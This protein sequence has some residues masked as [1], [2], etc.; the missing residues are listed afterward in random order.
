MWFWPYCVR[1]GSMKKYRSLG[2]LVL[3]LLLPL[4]S[5]IEAQ[6]SA[7]ESGRMAIDGAGQFMNA[8]VRLEALEPLVRKHYLRQN[9]YHQ[10]KYEPWEYT[11]YAREKYN[12]YTRVELEGE[13]WYD[14][15]GGYIT[16]GFGIYSWSQQQPQA[17]GSDVFKR[18][19]YRNWFNNVVIASDKKGQFYTALTVAD[20]IRTTLTPLTFSK[21]AFGGLQWDFLSDKYELTFLASRVSS[22]GFTAQ[23]VGQVEGQTT[24]SPVNLFGGRGTMQIGDFAKAGVTYVNSQINRTDRSFSGEGMLNGQLSSEQNKDLVRWITIRISDDSP[25]D[26]TGGGRLFSERIL[27]RRDGQSE[28]QEEDVRP[29][30]DGG[31]R[32]GGALAADGGETI[33]LTYTIPE[34]ENVRDIEFELVLSND[35]LVEATSNLQEPFFLPV[36]RAR[37][38]VSDGSNQKVIRFQ[39][40]LPTAHE[41]AGVSLEVIDILGF[42]LT[43]EYDVSRRHR[44]TPSPNFPTHAH[45]TSTASAWYV[46][47]NWLRYPY[48]AQ[49]EVFSIEPEYQTNMFITDEVGVINYDREDRHLFEFVD[50][51]DDADRTPDWNRRW[52]V[53]DADGIF[54]GWDENNDFRPDLNRNTNKIPDYEEPFLRYAVDP[55]E[56]LFGIDMNNNTIIDRFEDDELPDYP[57]KGDHHGNNVYIGADIM[58]DVRLVVG[59]SSEEMW[60]SEERARAYY[61]LFTID[62]TYPG[63]GR[64]RFSERAKLVKDNLQDDV[65]QWA[66]RRGTFGS[67]RVLFKDPL[68]A[69]DTWINTTFLGVDF[70]RIANLNSVNLVKYEIYHQRDPAAGLTDRSQFLGI[71]NKV[72]YTY[73]FRTLTIRPKLKSMYRYRTPFFED[74]QDTNELT[75]FLLLEVSLPVLDRSRLRFGVEQAIV[76][77]WVDEQNFATR[78]LA[79]QYSNSSAYLGYALKTNVGLSVETRTFRGDLKGRPDERFSNAFITIF[80]GLE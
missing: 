47:F 57:Y 16:R 20:E 13:T 33:L 69:Q 27:F 28:Q 78:T 53:R 26:G 22:P 31:F 24:T 1:E 5:R 37:G 71:I 72:D 35:Y 3:L 30:I 12:R 34:P 41:V 60:S 66:Q 4:G 2:I 62:R 6:D 32:R 76:T 70:N 11:N 48:F 36:A 64:L 75:E 77:D 44:K 54:P 59:R 7:T 23:Y 74:D 18:A 9:L 73:H 40:G 56:F 19:Q 14:V 15:F 68:I 29:L 58:P 51:N 55:P 79:V 80:A 42:R 52:S 25:E 17:F 63:F 50:D 61:A 39:Y 21:P 10:Y 46:N 49:G 65:L 43:G 67:D 45:S 38:D 8:S